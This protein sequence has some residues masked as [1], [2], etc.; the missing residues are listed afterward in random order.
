MPIDDLI[1]DLAGFDPAVI[2]ALGP[3]DVAALAGRALD[4]ADPHRASALQILA[5]VDPAGALAAAGQVVAEGVS[6]ALMATAIRAAGAAEEAAVP[7][8]MALAASPDDAVALAAWVTLAQIAGSD[9]LPALQLVAAQTSGVVGEQAAF[10]LSVIAYRAGLT[11]FEVPV[12]AAT[13]DVDIMLPLLS[14]NSGPVDDDDFALLTRMPRAERYKVGLDR[15][16]ITT[17]DCNGA[18]MLLATDADFVGALVDVLLPSPSLAGIVLLRDEARTSYSLRYLVLTWPDDA[19]GLL[20]S[21]HQPS[22]TQVY[23]SRAELSNSTV[24]M[25]LRTVEH[26]GAVPVQITTA[27]VGTSI[28]FTEAFSSELVAFSTPK[29]E[30]DIDEA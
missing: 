28:S 19:G 12:P 26:P 29:L 30:P 17:I 15:D 14:V 11:G 7:L 9:A 2:D 10:T 4:P 21:L 22:G 24:T 27:I 3:D 18:H 1:G 23:F 5:L 16:H 8:V 25:T 13:L 20:V 6:S